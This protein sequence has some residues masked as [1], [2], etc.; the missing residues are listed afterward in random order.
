MVRGPNLRRTLCAASV[1]LLLSLLVHGLLLLA[2][3]AWPTPSHSA[4]GIVSSTRIS[5]ETCVL[6]IGSPSLKPAPPL[7]AEPDA[8]DAGTTMEARLLDAPPIQPE[9]PSSTERAQPSVGPVPPPSSASAGSVGG[10]TAGEGGLFPLPATACSVVYVL[11][12]S[13]SMGERGKL[14]LACRQLLASLRQLPHSARFQ[15]ICYSDYAMP[16]IINNQTDL[17]RAEPANIRAAERVLKELTPSGKTN[18]ADALRRGLA[19]RPD[20]LYLVTDADELPY[21]DIEAVTRGNSV[22]ALHIVELTRRRT[23]Q[24]DSVMAQLARGNGGTY[25][26]VSLGE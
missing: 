20:V 22:T 2:L 14:D 11:D 7:P 24:T 6:D 16:L 25:R 9:T 3:W 18:H 13:L 15:I 19:L 23:P 17:L 8:P 12:R 26:R 5:L 4:G 1:P 10:T 21:A